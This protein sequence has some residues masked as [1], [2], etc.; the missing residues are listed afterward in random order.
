MTAERPLAWHFACHFVALAGLALAVVTGS[1]WI[2]AA[3]AAVGAVGATA[4]G[5]FFVILLRRLGRGSA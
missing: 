3:A 5:A 1:A 2:A 4:F